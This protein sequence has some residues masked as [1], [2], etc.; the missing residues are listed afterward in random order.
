MTL[1]KSL[2]LSGLQL[3]PVR[4][5]RVSAG[6]LVL[7]FPIGRMDSC[8]RMPTALRALAH[9]L[10]ELRLSRGPRLASPAPLRVSPAPLLLVGRSVSHP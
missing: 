9:L 6:L 10:G 4:R 8:S 7:S 3:P 2:N 5:E 1:A